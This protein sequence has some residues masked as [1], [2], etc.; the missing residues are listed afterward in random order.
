MKW[1]EPLEAPKWIVHDIWKLQINKIFVRHE[2]KKKVSYLLSFVFGLPFLT[3]KNEIAWKDVWTT[4]MLNKK[5]RKCNVKKREDDYEQW[6]AI[7]NNVLS[8]IQFWNFV[9]IIILAND[10]GEGLF[11]HIYT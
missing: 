9:S 7:G 4:E 10:R 5:N 1:S 11:F 3:T 6:N 8:F 2:L